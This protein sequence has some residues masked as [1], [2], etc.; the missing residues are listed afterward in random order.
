[1][2]KVFQFKEY[3]L[4]TKDKLQNKKAFESLLK[5]ASY[6]ENQIFLDVAKGGNALRLKNYVGTITTKENITIEILPKIYGIESDIEQTKDI[7]FRMLKTLKKSPFKKLNKTNIKSSKFHILEIFISMFLEEL[8]ELL[9][10]GLKS[11]YLTYANNEKFLKGKIKL[12]EQLRKNILN[13][14]KFFIEFDEY[15]SNRVENKLIKTSLQLLYNISISNSNKQIIREYLFVFDDVETSKDIELDFK[16]CKNDRSIMY[17]EQTLEWCKIF[18]SKKS[19]TPYKGNDNAHAIL[20]DMNLLFESYVASYFK[21]KFNYLNVKTQ[22]SKYTLLEEP[23]LFRLKPDIVIED[24]IV[25]DTKWK[26]INKKE[27]K[28]NISQSDMYQMYAYA[29][30]YKVNDIFLIY[31]K[32]LNFESSQDGSFLFEDDIRLKVLCFDC[33]KFSIDFIENDLENSLFIKGLKY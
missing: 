11:D 3:E 32:S 29:K 19:F 20:F 9:R 5:F 31:P 22:D 33:Q 2:S 25:L 30:K 17:Y 13:K 1:M 14:E 26:L 4:I 18:L 6:E 12:N 8:S 10:K 27:K 16:K 15:S 23:K 24:K 28:Y 21:K 7:L